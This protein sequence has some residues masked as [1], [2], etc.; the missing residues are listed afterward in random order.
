MSD[1][2]HELKEWVEK[3]IDQRDEAIDLKLGALAL[4][5]S[6]EVTTEIGELFRNGPISSLRAGQETLASKVESL[7]KRFDRLENRVLTPRNENR[8]E[9][10]S[11]NTRT[12]AGGSVGDV[13]GKFAAL[14]GWGKA[15]F[16]GAFALGVGFAALVFSG[17]VTLDT[18][19]GVLK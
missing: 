8:D 18:L 6:K 15:I 5:I 19:I 14:S 13:S 9:P 11:R 2:T 10:G 4:Q 7:S 1:E 12:Q 3:I 17:A 16:V